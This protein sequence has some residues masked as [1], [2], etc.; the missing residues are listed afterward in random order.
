ME[1]MDAY[2]ERE[3]LLYCP[4][5]W[6]DKSKTKVGYEIPFTK[7]FYECLEMEPADD[8]AKRKD[9]LMD[10]LQKFISYEKT[11]KK[12]VMPDGSTNIKK[13][14]KI[15]FPRYHQLDV[16]RELVRHVREN[17]PGH[18]YLIQHS[19]GSGKSNSIAWTAYRMASLHDSNNEAVYDSVIVVTDRRVLNQQLQATI[20][21]FDH[22]LGSVETI[23][24]KKSSKDLLNAINKGKRVIVT[25]LQ[26][27]PVI[28]EQVQSAVGKHY[29]IIVDE[30][31]SSQTGQSAMKLK[32]AL[33]DVS[34]ALEEYAEL[35]QK[36]VDEI[37]AK[38]I[39]VQDMLSQGKH[40][41]LSFFAFTATPKGKTLEI[42][43]EPQ[44]DGS[45]HP[46]RIYSMRQAI[47]E[48]FILDVLANYTTYKMCYQIAKNVPDN[49]DVPTSKAVRTI[50]RYEELHPHNL[51]QKAAII[52]ETF[53]DVTKHKIGGLGKMMVVTA[54]R[55]A[56]VRYYHEIKRYL[57][58]NDYDDIEIMIAFS[59]N[60][61][62]PDNPNSPEYTESSMNV[63]SNGNRVKESQTK[64]VFHDEGDILIVAEKYQTGFDEPLLHTMIVD[65]ELRDV[66]AV[67]TL[68]R[69]NR[70]YP[71]KVDTYVLDFV[72]D[73]DRI[74]EAFQQFYQETSLDE[75]IN[76]DLIYTTQKILRDFKV[77][78]DADIEAVSQI[79]FDPD[80]RK[81]NAT[82]GKISN[83]L[84]PVADKYNQLNQEQ[85]YQFRREV[86]AFVKWYNYISQITRMFDKEL[87]CFS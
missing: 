18:N 58:Q 50:R 87:H 27:F 85:R 84:K 67:Q 65:K 34:D 25:T 20:S 61:K 10:I 22:T 77:Y 12:E 70:T 56:A 63:D 30:A 59:G 64:S 6:I 9:N 39:L 16:V 66:K 7:T 28:Y 15:I 62:D 23:D 53:R 71:G 38:D 36:A 48:G 60:L 2:F 83:I 52:V 51:A 57:E 72:N 3:V 43:G 79:Y 42:F 5:A 76:F 14:E 4:G 32:A 54:S 21:S 17:G 35:E 40:R 11:E 73:V 19:A 44:L 81:A 33:A 75:E 49:P 29:A 41:N 80:I 37:E 69:L 46:F 55:L 13:T 31:H 68:S 82:Q 47:E 1:L 26:K 8:I 24:D 74:R 86:R 45:F 78:T